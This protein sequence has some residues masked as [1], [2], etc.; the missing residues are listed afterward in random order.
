M[1]DRLKALEINNALQNFPV[2]GIIGSRQVGKTTLAKNLLAQRNINGIYLDL[3]KPSDRTRLTN[4]ELFFELNKHQTIILDEVQTMPELFAI[5]RSS[6][7]ENRI[8]ARF[9]PLG[10]ASPELMRNT[11]DSLAGRI[12]Y[13]E[14]GP[15][16]YQ[17][18][19]AL[20]PWQDHWTFGG[21]PEPILSK[22]QPFMLEWSQS[23]LATYFMRDLPQLGLAIN[24][25]D[26]HRLAA[27]LAHN[28]GQPENHSALAR[29]LG[30]SSPTAKNAVNYFEQ[31]FIIR[32]LHPWFT[33]AKKRLVKSPKTYFRDTG[34]LHS[35]LQ[36]NDVNELMRHPVVGFSFEGYCIEQIIGNLGSKYRYYYYRTQ[37]GTEADLLAVTGNTV[38]FGFEIKLAGNP[39]IT[40][41]MR[42]AIQ[43]LQ[44]KKMFIVTPNSG[45]SPL[46][47]NIWLCGF[48]DI[49][50]N[51]AAD[52]SH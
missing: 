29:A 20:V 48:Q 33:N 4:P 40:K 47:E 15:L 11:A 32:R 2:V 49:T 3:E 30:I 21:Y 7:D 35:L 51:L 16:L 1:I 42:L 26:V 34:L 25:V 50:A 31:S 10:S 43:D 38:H 17:E 37:D 28:H 24:T 46:E 13:I 36:I 18:L 41:S 12:R 6:V 14:L 52:M 44:P 5:I 19:K 39:A 27:M 23:F 22:N 9:L 45:L 8:P